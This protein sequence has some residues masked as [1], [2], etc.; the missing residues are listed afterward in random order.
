MFE[1]GGE[2]QRIRCMTNHGEK[3]CYNVGLP[4]GFVF[5]PSF[6]VFAAVVIGLIHCL[7]YCLLRIYINVLIC[8][9]CGVNQLLS[10]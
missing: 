10:T 9:I 4:Y 2:G 5:M 7:E 6:S 1:V 3:F 8:F